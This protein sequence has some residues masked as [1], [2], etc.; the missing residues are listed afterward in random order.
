MIRKTAFLLLLLVSLLFH[1]NAESVLI[2]ARGEDSKKLDPADVVD[3][4]SVKVIVNVFETLVT[5][6]EDSADIVPALAEKWEVSKDGKSWTF[7]LRPNVKFHDGTAFNAEAVRFSLDRLLNPK[8]SYRFEGTFGYAGSYKMI[9]SIEVVDELTVRFSLKHPTV[10]FLPNLAMFPACIISPAAMKKHGNKFFR[11]PVGTGP[12]VFRQWRPKRKIVLTANPNYW[13]GKAGCDSIVFVPVKENASRALQLERGKIHMMDGVDF[14]DIGRLKKQNG[15]TVKT[16]PGMNMAYLAMNCDVK[17]FNDVRVRQAVAFAVNRKKILKLAYHG[18]GQPGVNPLPPT[19]WGYHSGIEARAT[20]SGNGR[21][22]L[23]QA[24]F[25]NGFKT[26][27]W[28]MPN[29]RPYMPQPRQV[30]QVLKESLKEIGIEVQIVSY[31]WN[32]YLD[33]TANGEHPMC[34]LGWSTDNADPDNFLYELLDKDK[35]VKGSA[36]NVCFFRN[37]R[38]HEVLVAAQKE[39]DRKKRKSLYWEAQSIIHRESPMI[40]LAYLPIVAA[41]SSRVKGYK[42]HPTG[43]VRLFKVRL[44]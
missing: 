23:K 33:R 17:P 25:P 34:L 44:D 36:N 27:L 32:Q 20:N 38:V 13:G 9:D 16:A 28:A 42:I 37:D 2:Y 21:Q 22:L 30:A 26:Q 10:I 7:K 24:G 19:V 12:F 31:D 1:C 5:Y 3:G 35:A 29:P 41:Y 6:A 18:Y 43:I 39:F 8:N 40:P 15:V 4:E 11:N 14:T